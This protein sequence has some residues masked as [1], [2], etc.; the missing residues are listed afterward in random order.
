MRLR[1]LVGGSLAGF[2]VM[3]VFPALASAVDLDDPAAQWLPRTDGAE[4][5][6]TWSDSAYAPVAR[7]ERYVLA[8]RDDRD[9]RLGWNEVGVPADQEPIAGWLDFRASD[10]GLLNVNYQSTPAPQRF[11]LLCPTVV[12]CGNSLSGSLFLAIWGARSPVIA[13]P[14]V[15]GATWNSIGGA[16]NDVVAANTYIGREKITVPA[17]G[18]PINTAKI[19]SVVT[20]TGAL[21][22]P[23]GSGVRTVWWAYGVGPVQIQFEHNGGETSTSQLTATT[24]RL[25]AAPERSRPDA[26]QARRRPAASAGATT[27]A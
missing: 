21:G 6:Y 23:F 19:R 9:F 2:V 12:L 7:T 27:S 14:L 11:P 10:A 1:R 24:L 5:T 4:W 22:D 20:Q 18:V 16:G 3:A 8:Q 15:Q 25:E 17:F 13:E 26:A